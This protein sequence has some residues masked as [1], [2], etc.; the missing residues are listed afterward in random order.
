[1]VVPFNKNRYRS[2]KESLTGAS[3]LATDPGNVLPEVSC[4][5]IELLVGTCSSKKSYQNCISI[6]EDE[7]WTTFMVA[8]LPS[9]FR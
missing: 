1:M 5:V 3:V 4:Q 9:A 8:A 7:S 6:N 2:Q